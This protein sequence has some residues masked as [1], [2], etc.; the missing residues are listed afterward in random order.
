MISVS[1]LCCPVCWELLKLLGKE[2]ELNAGGGHPVFS[3][4]GCHSHIYPV[5]LPASIS[6]KVRKDMVSK[7]LSY[8]GEELMGLVSKI[9]RERE[10]ER[11]GERAPKFTHSRH[12]SAS[13]TMSR[14]SD[15][16]L[17]SESSGH[18]GEEYHED[19]CY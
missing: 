4:R 19:S 3:V 8:L 5:V 1:K 14:E 10:K 9:E 13:S 17:G 16:T 15:T 11:E 6:P 12:S 2:E 7:F 18:P